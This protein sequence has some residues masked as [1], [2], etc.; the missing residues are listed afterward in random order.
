MKHV[1]MIM[2]HSKD[3]IWF[4]ISRI[5]LRTW[6]ESFAY[7]RTQNVAKTMP[8]D[9]LLRHVLFNYLWQRSVLENVIILKQYNVQEACHH[10]QI[11]SSNLDHWLLLFH[12]SLNQ[13]GTVDKDDDAEDQ[14]AEVVATDTY[15]ETHAKKGRCQFSFD[16]AHHGV[17]SIRQF[18]WANLFKRKNYLIIYLKIDLSLLYPYLREGSNPY[19]G[20][21]GI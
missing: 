18:G 10:E 5:L 9:R 2:S 1:K 14:A 11:D 7:L 12:V 13:D 4:I 15:E 19:F 8:T 21:A 16:Y 3:P 17:N 20:I 6:V